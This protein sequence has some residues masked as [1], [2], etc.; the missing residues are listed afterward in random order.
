MRNILS[1]DT[2][3]VCHGEEVDTGCI[4]LV[5]F[6]DKLDNLLSGWLGFLSVRSVRWKRRSTVVRSTAI[7]NSLRGSCI[8]F[9]EIPCLCD[10]TLLLRETVPSDTRYSVKK[11]SWCRKV[12][13][14]LSCQS[15]RIEGDGCTTMPLPGLFTASLRIRDP[16]RA[17]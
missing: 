17:R 3:L 16:S 2:A 5:D 11:I 4:Q 14:G 9:P 7:D 6:F 15:A 13:P 1:L 10:Q 8:V 12:N